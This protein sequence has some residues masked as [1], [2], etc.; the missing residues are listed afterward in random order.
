MY[1]SLAFYTLIMYP[2]LIYTDLVLIFGTCSRRPPPLLPVDD[3]DDGA[4]LSGPHRAGNAPARHSTQRTRRRPGADGKPNAN[5]GV[6]S[7]TCGPDH[8]H[9]PEQSVHGLMCPSKEVASRPASADR[10]RCA[11]AADGDE[12]ATS[13][14]R[15]LN[16]SIF[17][18]SP[19]AE[20][21]IGTQPSPS[22]P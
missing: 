21:R 3:G 4:R 1:S 16:P 22:N 12:A 17:L 7:S 6:G 2:L 18:A 19:V 9:G 8:R 5:R 14:R 20:P 10:R 15:D 11:K 13:S